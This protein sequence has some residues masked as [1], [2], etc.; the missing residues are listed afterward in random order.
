MTD[1]PLLDSRFNLDQIEQ[2]LQ[3]ALPAVQLVVLFGS[4]ATGRATAKSDW[5]L[6]VLVEPGT[7][8]GF[9]QLI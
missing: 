2:R 6:G 4:Q 7:H 3:T 8:E 5:D 1:K 9:E